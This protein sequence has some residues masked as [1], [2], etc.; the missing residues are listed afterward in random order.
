MN[1]KETGEL[2]AQNWPFLIATII[3]VSPIIWGLASLYYSGRIETLREQSNLLKEQRDFLERKVRAIETIKIEDPTKSYDQYSHIQEI[4]S[5]SYPPISNPQKLS[6]NEIRK[7]ANFYELTK[8][9]KSNPHLKMKDGDIAYWFEQGLSENEIKLE[10]ESRRIVLERA[11]KSNQVI[12]TQ[13]DLS[14]L[15]QKIQAEIVKKNNR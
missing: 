15:A 12:D 3:V 9:W 7:L 14:Y 1:I 5:L 4:E 10:F 2:I 6:K 13:G 11:D 8:S